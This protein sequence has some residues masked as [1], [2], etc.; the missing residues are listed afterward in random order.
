MLTI[1]R[2][3]ISQTLFVGCLVQIL[4]R[5]HPRRVGAQVTGLPYLI[6]HHA[7]ATL[8][9]R[10]WPETVS[11]FLVFDGRWIA[12]NAWRGLACVKVRV[13]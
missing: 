2:A 9:W 8:H 4:V 13:A 11:N 7:P 12:L 3:G 1:E 5:N 10:L 6:R